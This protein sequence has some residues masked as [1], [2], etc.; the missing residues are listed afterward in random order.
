M[1]FVTLNRALLRDLKRKGFNLLKSFA[2]TDTQ[3][4]T[5]QPVRVSDVHEYIL[6]LKYNTGHIYL[7]NAPLLVIEEALLHI[8]D[9]QLGGEVF[10]E[11]DH[12][13]KLQHNCKLYDLRYHFST[14]PEIYDFSFDPQR[15][16]IRNHAIRTCDYARYLEYLRVY[17]PYHIA[18]EMKDLHAL[19]TA[20]VCMDA[21]QAYKWFQKHEVTVVESDIWICDEDAILKVLAVKKHDKDWNLHNDVEEMIHNLMTPEELLDLRELFWID[22]RF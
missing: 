11:E 10:M 8:Q 7:K 17:Y 16:L 14:N 1:P 22:T 21:D 2:S 19:T 18:E 20:L 12:L 15:L 13:S 6:Q 9:D 3:N 5:W 4:P